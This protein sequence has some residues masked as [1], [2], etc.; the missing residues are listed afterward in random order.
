M[1]TAIEHQTRIF[2]GRALPWVDIREVER[3]NPGPVR[4]FEVVKGGGLHRFRYGFQIAGAGT[5]TTE[6]TEI[7][8]AYRLAYPGAKLYLSPGR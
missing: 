1:P 2:Q 6:M 8:R 4:L 7:I 3:T 5:S